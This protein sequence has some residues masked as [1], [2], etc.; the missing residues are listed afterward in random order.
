MEEQTAKK[1]SKIT[2]Y[3]LED[4]EKLGLRISA[5]EREYLANGFSW[6]HHIRTDV[7]GTVLTGLRGSTLEIWASDIRWYYDTTYETEI[8][9]PK[10]N[11]LVAPAGWSFPGALQF[12][13][14]IHQVGGVFRQLINKEG[15]PQIVDLDP[16]KD[17]KVSVNDAGSGDNGGAFNIWAKAY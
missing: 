10:G 3:S 2:A 7:V 5:D 8:T 14:V 4:V 1:T 6:Y 17:V 15:D 16:G 12:G 11:G 9:S 13:I